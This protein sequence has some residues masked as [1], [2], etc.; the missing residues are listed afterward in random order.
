M[1][2]Y[3]KLVKKTDDRLISCIMWDTLSSHTYE[4]GEWT[5]RRK[6]E[7][8]R[9]KKLGP[10][11]VFDTLEDAQSFSHLSAPLYYPIYKCRIRRSTAKA[12]WDNLLRRESVYFLP[13]G[14]VLADAVMLLEEVNLDD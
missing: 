7:E 10:L 5:Y 6:S 11:C 9:G 4:V 8:R 14:T 13:P 12:V 3:Y 2:Y 1:K